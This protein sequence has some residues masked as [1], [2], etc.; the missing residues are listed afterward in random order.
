MKE[1]EKGMGDSDGKTLGELAVAVEKALLPLGFSVESCGLKPELI[2]R[3]AA[4]CT[5]V[6]MTIVRKGTVG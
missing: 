2:A 5:E 6:R 1:G 3:S 4:E